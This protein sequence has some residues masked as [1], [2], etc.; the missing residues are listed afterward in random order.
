MTQ[1]PQNVL[2]REIH[3][4]AWLKKLP[5]VEKRNGAFPKK[6]ERVWVVFCVHDDSEAL[7]ELYT[8]QKLAVAHKPDWFISLNNCLHVSPTICAQEDEYEFVITLSSEVIRLA[9]PS[10]ELMMEWVETIRSKLQEMRI[11]SPRENLYSRMPEARLPLAPTRDPNSPLPPT[12]YGP[13]ARV[14]GIEPV[15]LENSDAVAV[16]ESVEPTSMDALASTSVQQTHSSLNYESRPST[17]FYITQSE[18]PVYTRPRHVLNRAAS[19]PDSPSVYSSSLSHSP[20]LRNP[21]ISNVTVIEV[22][23]NHPVSHSALPFDSGDVFNFNLL[24]EALQPVANG[25]TESHEEPLPVGSIVT[26]DLSVLPGPSRT[27]DS[28]NMSSVTISNDTYSCDSSGSSN[29]S[30][31]INSISSSRQ[32]ENSVNSHAS[33]NCALSSSLQ[34]VSEVLSHYEC[35]FLPTH[36]PSSSQEV[37][38]SRAL[39]VPPRFKSSETNVSS[40]AS[41]TTGAATPPL[42]SQQSSAQSSMQTS[43]QGSTSVESPTV[44]ASQRRRSRST[45]ASEGSSPR[46]SANLADRNRGA[47]GSASGVARTE[48]ERRLQPA[49]HPY[50]HL[51]AMFS[52]DSVNVGR[53]TLREQ[54]VMQ[55]RREMLHPGGVRLQLRRKD[56]TNS[57]AL[58]DAFGAVW[59]AGW[60]QKEHPML[61][62][63]LH[64][65]DHL[66]STGGVPVQN[67]SDAQK[68][69]RGTSS[70]YVEFVIRRVPCGRVF[71]IRR[72]TE[73]QS[74]GIVQEGNTAEIRDVLPGSPAARFGLVPRAPTCDGLSLTNWILTEING[75]PL[76]LFFKDGEVRDRLNA[77]GRD[78]S[79]LVQPADLVKQLKKQ[80]KS[81]RGYKDYIVQ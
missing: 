78:I 24:D 56:C 43:Q 3:K 72:E 80:L 31:S 32:E 81:I 38:A 59:V 8:D 75:R 11:L 71:A 76:N 46:V 36:S 16:T 13:S 29:S 7:L 42:V 62:N 66:V 12:P 61:Y 20:G 39:N 1:N 25:S 49:P 63:A 2:F 58:V 15:H 68:L 23:A 33:V 79:I 50:R 55:L 37:G 21:S 19:V 44:G 40:S 14:P 70:L 22:S 35:V 27:T 48:G 51:G 77:V 45:S 9:A 26:D 73:G 17:A 65:G 74:L 4:N 30:S 41:R 60:K 69:I 28:H 47:S 10:W 6:G 34:D 5:T 64:I 54:Q 67:A 57:I 18:P 52:A 53:L